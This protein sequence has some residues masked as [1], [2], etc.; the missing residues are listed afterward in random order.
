[1]SASWVVRIMV[2]NTTFNNISVILWQS[3]LLVEESGVPGENHQC[4]VG[5]ESPLLTSLTKSYYLPMECMNMYPFSIL[6]K[7]M[8]LG[9]KLIF[10]YN[11]Y[12]I[13]EKR[14]DKRNGKKY[15]D[16]DTSISS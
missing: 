11:R 15:S 14:K 12:T 3:V 10:L 7:T 5:F 2:F 4:S 8:I 6:S 9:N 1:M 13:F 16:I